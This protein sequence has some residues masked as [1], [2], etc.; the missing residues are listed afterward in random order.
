MI[1]KYPRMFFALLDKQPARVKGYA[2]QGPMPSRTIEAQGN[3]S[4]GLASFLPKR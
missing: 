2:P 4:R 3:L 1:M